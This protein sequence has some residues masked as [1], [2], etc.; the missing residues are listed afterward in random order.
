[1]ADDVAGGAGLVGSRDRAAV[2]R[3]RFLN[4]YPSHPKATLAAVNAAISAAVCEY[5]LKWSR[6]ARNPNSERFQA[7]LA[8]IP[9]GLTIDRA[10]LLPT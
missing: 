5:P 10:L 1:M 3:R 7:M 4:Q 2:H 6:Y 8:S 9:L